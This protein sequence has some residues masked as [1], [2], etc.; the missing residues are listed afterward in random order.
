M[1]KNI[2]LYTLLHFNRYANVF[3]RAEGL[4]F[5]TFHCKFFSSFASSFCQ[6]YF[7]VYLIQSSIKYYAVF[8]RPEVPLCPPPHTESK[9]FAK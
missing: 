9:F 4:T 5:G 1:R 2:S 6:L 7:P 8:D 3:L